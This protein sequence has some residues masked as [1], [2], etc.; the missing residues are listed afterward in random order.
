MWPRSPQSNN[1]HKGELGPNPLDA[2]EDRSSREPC[3]PSTLHCKLLPGFHVPLY[4]TVLFGGYLGYFSFNNFHAGGV[5]FSF[6]SWK[7]KTRT[8][9]KALAPLPWQAEQP[10][11][12]AGAAAFLPQKP[13]L[14]QLLQAC[15]SLSRPRNLWGE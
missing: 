7:Q 14:G 4:P 13:A 1:L 3:R 9:L 5:C 12:A 10:P 2:E 15:L 6:S 11:P 8:T